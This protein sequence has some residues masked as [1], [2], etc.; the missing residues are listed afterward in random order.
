MART[1]FDIPYAA[2]SKAQ[3]LDIYLPDKGEGP[4]PAL[5]YIHGGGFALGDKRDEH[6]TPY[7]KGI[8]KGMAVVSVEYR[9]SG[10]AVFPA[11]VLDCRAAIRFIKKNAEDYSID[12]SKIV[13][14]GGSAGGNLAAMLGMNIPNGQFP[15]ESESVPYDEIPVVKCTVDQFGPMN[16]R[17]MDKQALENGISKVEH[18]EPFSPESKYLGCTLADVPD[19]LCAKANPATYINNAMCPIL[20]Q[21]GT[22]DRLV[23]Y[24]QSIEFVESIKTKL[25]EEYVTFLPVEGADHDDEKFFADENMEKVFTFIFQHL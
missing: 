14:I 16:F 20:V 4:F 5:V 24:G 19:E 3:C 1:Y 8:E 15:G 9:L 6:V 2:G 25:G 23:P 18:D 10:E 21:H 13:T 12:A 11:A 17:T 7:L 22:M